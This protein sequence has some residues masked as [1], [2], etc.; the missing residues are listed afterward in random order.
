MENNF[1]VDVSKDHRGDCISFHGNINTEATPHFNE[2]CNKIS[3]DCV[4]MDFSNV[5]RVNSMGIALLL[6]TIN[7]IKTEKRA[8]V[9]FQGVNQINE[10]LFRITGV[11]TLA[12]PNQSI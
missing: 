1:R 2:L 12:T 3:G 7:T 4:F 10:L 11:S 9:C 5:G 6:R 8:E